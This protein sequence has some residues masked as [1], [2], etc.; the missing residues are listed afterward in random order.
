M[1]VGVRKSNRQK[2]M[3]WKPI[4]WKGNQNRVENNVTETAKFSTTIN[5]L[6][7]STTHALANNA[8]NTLLRDY[9]TLT[10]TGFDQIESVLRN[11]LNQK[12]QRD[13]KYWANQQ[14]FTQLGVKLEESEWGFGENANPQLTFQKL[15][16]KTVFAQF[17]SMSEDFFVKDPLAGQNTEEATRILRNAGIHA[18]GIAPCADGR[19]AHFI[20]YV[21]RLPY[22]VARRKSHAGALFD[23]SESVR[24]WVFV[25]HNRFRDGQPNSAEETTRY[26]KIAVYH[27]SKAAPAKQGCAAHGSDD[28]KAGEAALLRLRDFRQAI[29]NRFGCGSTIETI[30]IGVNTDDDSLK[31]HIPNIEGRVSLDRFVETDQLYKNTLNLPAEEAREV[32]EEAIAGCNVLKNGTAPRDGIKKLLAWFIENNFSQIE[33]VNQYEQSCYQDIGHAERFIG[34]GNG[35]E[36]VQLRNLS[37]YSFLDTIEEGVN[38]VDV[39]IKIFKGLNVKRGIPIPIIIRCD[40]DGRVPGSRQRATKKAERLEKAVH[41]RYSELSA[42]GLV[43]TLPTLRDYTGYQPA[44]KLPVESSSH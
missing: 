41:A 43:Y 2:S 29:E 6:S 14:L 9:E 40:Y 35:F 39:G 19:L 23:I 33:Y 8:Q 12:Y 21:L 26:L 13:F 31:V 37:Y 17:L 15:Y 36:E 7:P 42:C 38:D 11:I 25:E 3:F 22:A 16:A 34:I 1:S 20:S 18:V 27:F 5:T 28:H 4:P 10:K 24:N 32:L 44:E 30:L